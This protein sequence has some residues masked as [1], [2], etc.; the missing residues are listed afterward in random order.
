MHLFARFGHDRNDLGIYISIWLSIIVWTHLQHI[1]KIMIKVCS[2][3]K[4]HI[5]AMIG[6]HDQSV[7]GV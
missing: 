2:M 6:R 4:V 7:G 3:E 5:T 1:W